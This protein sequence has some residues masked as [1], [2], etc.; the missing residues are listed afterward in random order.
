MSKEESNK[1][2]SAE[3]STSNNN[4]GKSEV[5]PPVLQRRD[6]IT[7]QFSIQ[8]IVSQLRLPLILKRS[9]D[10]SVSLVKLKCLKYG[11]SLPIIFHGSLFV[12]LKCAITIVNYDDERAEH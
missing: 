3:T 12:D 6:S 9:L 2:T 11:E 8:E 7:S 5:E 4:G 1:N 10:M